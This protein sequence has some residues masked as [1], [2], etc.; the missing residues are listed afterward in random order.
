MN[1]L[2]TITAQTMSSV[3]IVKMI[4]ELREDGQAEL[5]HNDFTEKVRKVI[6]LEAAKFSAPLKTASG[7]TAQGYLLPK[8]EAQLMVMSESYK[9]QAAVYDRMVELEAKIPQTYI[10]ALQSLIESEIAKQKALD[11]VAKL[12]VII[13]NALGYSSIIRASIYAGVHENHFSWRLLKSAAIGIGLPPKRVPSPR[14]GYQNLYPIKA[15]EQAYPDIDFD[16]LKPE[17]VDDKAKLTL[18]A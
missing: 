10:Q 2:S 4:N 3:E 7:Q 11:D 8:R 15:F 1:E 5:R 18:A 16:D 6:G 9:V 12:N 14:F 13:D 17:L